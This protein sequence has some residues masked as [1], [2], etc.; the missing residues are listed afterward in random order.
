MFMPSGQHP[1]QKRVLIVDDHPI[2]RLGLF[3]LI[4]RQ[5]D[6]EVLRGSR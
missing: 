5:L 4:N 2:T 1:N 6:L 3:Y